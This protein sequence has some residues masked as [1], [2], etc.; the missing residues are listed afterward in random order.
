MHMGA[1]TQGMGSWQRCCLKLWLRMSLRVA[2][3]LRLLRVFGPSLC[4][5]GRLLSIHLDEA[6]RSLLA[7]QA[8]LRVPGCG[9]LAYADLTLIKS[10]LFAVRLVGAHVVLFEARCCACCILTGRAEAWLASGKGACK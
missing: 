7:R 2:S 3:S 5:P 10:L 1:E 6:L 9:Q 8:G 4:L